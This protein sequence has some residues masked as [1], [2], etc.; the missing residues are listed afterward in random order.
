MSLTKTASVV[1]STRSQEGVAPPPRLVRPCVGD[2]GGQGVGEQPQDQHVATLEAT[3]VR[4]EGRDGAERPGGSP[5]AALNR[6]HHAVSEQSR[7][8]GEAPLDAEI[9]DDDGAVGDEV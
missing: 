6:R 3:A 7:V 5:D 1:P 2:R 8:R 4:R 9:L